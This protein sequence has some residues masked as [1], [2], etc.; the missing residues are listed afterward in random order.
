M[1]TDAR[2]TGPMRRLRSAVLLLSLLPVLA[3]CGDSS[4]EP[5]GLDLALVVG[6]YDLTTLRFDPQGTLGDTDVFP[7]LGQDNVQLI[8][9][10]SRTAQVVFQDPIT[11]LFTTLQ[12][13][14][15]TT[16]TGVRIEFSSNAPYRDLLLSRRM[17][18]TLSGTSLSFDDLAPDGV[19]RARL[20]ELVPAFEE[21]Q[22]LDPTPGRLRVT[23]ARVGST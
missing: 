8:L 10:P 6:T 4:T 5:E 13:S 11:A 17:E 18:Y 19:Q 16:E 22:L 15:R 20:L 9:T 3:A 7:V 1:T 2:P 23:F 21:E 14:F 12:A